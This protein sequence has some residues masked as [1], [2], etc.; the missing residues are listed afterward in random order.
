MIGTEMRSEAIG[1]KL[2]G[3][4]ETR[5]RWIVYLSSIDSL[6]FSLLIHRIVS[7]FFWNIRYI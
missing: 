2:L 4:K 5:W 1:S 3:L 6:L 7:F